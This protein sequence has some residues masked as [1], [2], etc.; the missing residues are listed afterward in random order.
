MLTD[1]LNKDFF[2]KFKIILCYIDGKCEYWRKG[3]W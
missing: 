1:L 3:G 2:N